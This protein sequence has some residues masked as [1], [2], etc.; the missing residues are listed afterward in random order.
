M[1]LMGG[2]DDTELRMQEVASGFGGRIGFDAG[3]GRNGRGNLSG[4]G[5]SIVHIG[6]RHLGI[7]R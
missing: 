2:I 7:I 4:G 1:C 5:T 3:F 6:A